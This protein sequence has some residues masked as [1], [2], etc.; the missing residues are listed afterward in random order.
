M[1]VPIFIERPSKN[2]ASFNEKTFTLQ[3]KAEESIE[4]E[5]RKPIELELYDL[6]VRNIA[7]NEKYVS[8]ARGTSSDNV[9]AAYVATMRRK[10]S[11]GEML[12]GVKNFS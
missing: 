4:K 6:S 1:P 8:P 9:E 12:R 10:I 11:I 7:E 3:I 2:G 5:G